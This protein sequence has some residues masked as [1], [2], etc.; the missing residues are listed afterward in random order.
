VLIVDPLD[1]DAIAEALL[2]VL[3]DE[4]VRADLAQRGKTY[5]LARTWAAAAQS[6]VTLWSSLT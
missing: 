2:V 1:V 6:H 3:T 5:A 4:A